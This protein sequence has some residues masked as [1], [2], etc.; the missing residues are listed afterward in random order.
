M[1]RA[2]VLV[3]SATTVAATCASGPAAEPTS[4]PT[5]TAAAPLGGGTGGTATSSPRATTAAPPSQVS[6]HW[7]RITG[8]LSSPV[9]V[10]SARDGS[11]RLF[12]VEQGGVVRRVSHGNVADRPYLDIEGRVQDGGE[13][14][15]LSI[16][17][18]PRFDRH[19]KVYA[20][21]TR[22]NGDLIVSWFRPKS[23]TSN[24]VRGS[25]EH[26]LLLVPHHQATNHNGGQL[27]FG[28]A[29]HL[30]YITTGDGGGA[31]DGFN[32]AGKRTKLS[33]KILRID[34]DRKCGG[35][36]YCIPPSNPYAHSDRYRREILDWGLRNPWRAGID[37]KTGKMWVG[38]VGQDEWEEIDRVGTRQAHDFGWSCKEGRSTYNAGRCIGRHMTGPVAVI[39]HNGSVCAIIGGYV[40]RGHGDEFAHGLYVFSDY[41]SGDVW[42]TRHTS[43]GYATAHIGT[44]S[45]GITGFGLSGSN[46]LLAVTQDGVLKRAS[47]SRR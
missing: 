27:F 15:L 17:F 11:G 8:G 35:K 23:A 32:L 13:Q 31:G 39:P 12:I 4:S 34:V 30:L 25:T 21:Y 20:A 26:R 29:D 46:A 33:G 22:D 36:S 16:A 43:S 3:L 10:T 9:S 47:F 42:A 24:H 28:P 41:C 5:R 44:I 1:R 19:P 2:L 40:Y 45:G 38:D 14:G 6:I 37:V 7:H 18:H